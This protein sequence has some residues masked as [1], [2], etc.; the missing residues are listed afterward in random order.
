[1]PSVLAY[2]RPTTLDEAVDLLA[3]PNRRA[4]GGG[5]VAVPEGRTPTDD[6]VELVDLQA[7]GLDGVTVQ[8]D[9]LVIGAMVR[10]GDLAGTS[11]PTNP[12]I[13]DIPELIRDLAKRELPSTLRNQATIGGTVALGDSDSWLLAGLLVHGTQ[14]HL[15][16]QE[17]ISLEQSLEEC[18]GARVVTAVSIE[19]DGEASEGRT[20]IAGTGRTP[21]DVPI[22][23]AVAR[24]TGDQ[25]RLALTG[26][27]P[28][29]VLVD[30]T[31]P[32]A[33]LEPP[34]DFRGSASYRRHLA[35]T[36]SARVTGELA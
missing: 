17:P 27:A 15:H 26:M 11:T 6:G 9:R 16:G 13:P 21:A 20:A 2:H 33:G 10:L 30:P 28:S 8:G 29:P 25:L 35:T 22:V 18:V 5:T 3:E 4:I 14:V 1:M 31:D 32:A 7:L 24:R 34:G 23:A 19:F 12:D 36:L